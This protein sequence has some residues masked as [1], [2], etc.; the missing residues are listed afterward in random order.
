MSDELIMMAIS[1]V[2]TTIGFFA[3]RWMSTVDTALSN[4]KQKFEKLNTTLISLE[5]DHVSLREY[6]DNV[7]SFKSNSSIIQ[8]RLKTSEDRIAEVKESIRSVSVR[9]DNLELNLLAKKSE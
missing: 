2:V 9:L 3:V 5:K 7:N 4:L 8:Q 6:S 1:A